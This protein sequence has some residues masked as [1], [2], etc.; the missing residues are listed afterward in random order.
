[1]HLHLGE[2][3]LGE[4]EH[5]EPPQILELK[6]LGMLQQGVGPVHQEKRR[7]AA[8]VD[9]RKVG[10]LVGKIR[11]A[12]DP[13]IQDGLPEQRQWVGDAHE[14]GAPAN[15]GPSQ[16]L[17]IGGAHAIDGINPQRFALGPARELMHLPL[18]IEQRLSL[19]HI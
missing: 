18:G 4:C 16:P 8:E 6:S 13:D 12:T 1:M 5:R 17:E 7:I 3:T 15:P 9:H 2:S 19:I 10:V 11:I 14:V